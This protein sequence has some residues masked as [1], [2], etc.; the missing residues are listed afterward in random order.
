MRLDDARAGARFALVLVLDA[1]LRATA[2]PLA[3]ASRTANAARVPGSGGQ[4][5]HQTPPFH[6]LDTKFVFGVVMIS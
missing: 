1:D 4:H 6:G 3:A 2:T 5:E